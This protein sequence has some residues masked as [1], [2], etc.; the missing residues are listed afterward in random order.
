MY[1]FPKRFHIVTN[2]SPSN[3]VSVVNSGYQGN[4][5]SYTQKNQNQN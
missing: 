2:K 4:G 1:S 3:Y 5:T